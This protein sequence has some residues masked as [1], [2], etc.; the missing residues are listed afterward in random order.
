MSEQS[1]QQELESEA[2]RCF[3]AVDTGDHEC[4]TGEEVR[5]LIDLLNID[6]GPKANATILTEMLDPKG[7]KVLEADDMLVDFDEFFQWYTQTILMN[8]TL[9]IERNPK[10]FG[11]YDEVYTVQAKDLGHLKEILKRVL[12]FYDSTNDIDVY[13]YDEH[14]KKS[15]KARSLDELKHASTGTCPKNGLKLSIQVEEA[16]RDPMDR[17]RRAF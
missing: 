8:F 10:L 9:H 14:F 1:L 15:T 16:S 13:Y 12:Q 17:R 5:R 11:S 4:L 3:A 7:E 6:V 2:K